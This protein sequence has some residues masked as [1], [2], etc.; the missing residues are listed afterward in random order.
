MLLDLPWPLA[1]A[2]VIA[3]VTCLV[4]CKRSADENDGGEL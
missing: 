4:I 3:F 1:L 2:A